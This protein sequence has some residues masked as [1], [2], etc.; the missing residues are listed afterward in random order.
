MT[1]FVVALHAEAKP[2]IDHYGL[3]PADGPAF[4]VFEGG[5]RR[6]VV[7][8]VGKVAAAAATTYLHD[9][10]L[11]AWV[12][13]GIAGHRDRAPGEIVLASRVSD[14][15]T[16]E[17]YFPTLV[18]L[19]QIDREG[20]TTVDTPETAFAS[21]DVFDMEA[22]GYYPTA[23]R[24]ST[25]ELVHCVKIVSDN[26][27]TGTDALTAKRIGALVEKNLERIAALVDQLESLATALEPLRT[28]PELEPFIHSW[29]FTSS[30]RRRLFRLLV[31]HGAFERRPS[32]E[33][34]R[35][36]K[37]AAAV[38]SQLAENLETLA[39]EQQCF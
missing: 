18:G 33:D 15:S 34:F 10:P 37:N 30:Q 29:H 11:D 19:S 39:S 1:H 4:H 3:K 20:V 8:G 16:D 14:G 23:L 13:V 36:S 5:G 12:N 21:N 25:S 22:S 9:A 6:L 35:A 26:R 38:L 24:F 27:E 7:S 32:A 31:R 28:T 2:L 17:R